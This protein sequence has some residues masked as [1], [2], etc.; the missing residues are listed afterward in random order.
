MDLFLLR[1]KNALKSV[2]L[3]T[4]F[5]LMA[6]LL[7]KA[8]VTI[9]SIA[10]GDLL[11]GTTGNYVLNGTVGNGPTYFR[12]NNLMQGVAIDGS[13]N[14]AFTQLGTSTISRI[15]G[16]HIINFP[17]A[18][19]IGA[20]AIDRDNEF[21]Y[22]A[23]PAL[24]E[25]TPGIINRYIWKNTGSTTSIGYYVGAAVSTSATIGSTT[26][27]IPFITT[28][29]LVFMNGAT[30]ATALTM[31]L[32]NLCLAFDPAGNLYYADYTNN[33]VR[34][35]SIEK[36]TPA[37]AASGTTTIT[38]SAAPS[39]AVQIGD[40]VS[41]LFIPASTYITA[42]SGSSITLSKATTGAID[43]TST[44]A[45]ITGVSDI[46]NTAGTAGGV[47]AANFPAGAIAG[48]TLIQL[49]YGLTFDPSGNM[50]LAD[51]YGLNPR[52][53]KI[54]APVSSTSAIAIFG[55]GYGNKIQGLATDVNGNLY[56]ADKTNG[57][58]S[59]I[60]ANGGPVS[61][62][63]G[64][65]GSL[66]LSAYTT[67]AGSP[68]ISTTDITNL[69]KLS[70]G[71]KIRGT[72][73]PNAS[74]VVAINNTIA[75]YTVTI[76]NPAG[77]TAAT[78][79]G[80]AATGSTSLTVTSGGSGGIAAGQ[81]VIGAGIAPNTTVVSVSGTTVTLSA[82]TSAPLAITQLFFYA[83]TVF[84][85]QV[86]STTTNSSS[87]DGFTTSPG[88]NGYVE[89]PFGIAVS[90][91]ANNPFIV[92]PEQFEKYVRKISGSTINTSTAAL[93][94]ITSFT[95]SASALAGATI[96]ITG[97]NFTGATAVSFG[98][99][100]AASF[101]VV[102]ATSITAVI[103][104]GTTG[105]IYVT[106]PGGTAVSS[107][108][109]KV[110]PVISSFTPTSGPAGGTI[111]IT[112]NNFLGATAVT[113]GG[114]TAASFT[115]NGNTTITAVTGASATGPIAVTTAAGTGTS[116]GTFT[117][118]TAPSAL[119]YSTNTAAVN[120]GT[121]GT[122][123]TP[124][125]NG[126]APTYNLS[127]T[128]PA[129]ISI[130]AT[131]GVISYAAT[132]SAGTYALSVVATNNFPGST[133]A[134]YTITVSAVAPSAL[135]Y[136]QAT[137]TA[138]Y[139]IAGVSVAP[140]INNGGATITY[141]LG[142]TVPTGVSID[143]ST[144]IIS[145][146][147]TLLAGNYPLTIISTNSAG[148]TTASYTI[149]ISAI[150]PSALVY[151]SSTTTANYGTAGTSVTPTINNGGAAITYSLDGTVPIGISIDATTGVISYAA[152]LNAGTYALSVLATNS[153]SSTGVTYTI[154]VSA[155]AP[156]ALAYSPA[157][158]SANYSTS[159]VS[160]APT[161]N[162]GGATI[163]YSLSGTVPVGISIDATTGIISY[164]ATLNVGTYTLS[165]IATNSAGN[166][167]AAYTLTVNAIAPSLLVYNPVSSTTLRGT[168][169]V[170]ASPS[171][172]N[173][174]AAI[175]YSLSGTV[176]IGISINATTGV[177]SYAAT[178]AAGTYTLSVVAT[179]SAGNTTASYSITVSPSS[180]A[181]LTS[182][183]VSSGAL[184]PIFDA[185]TTSYVVGV[186]TGTSSITFTPT[187]SDNG[188][189]SVKVNGITVT[190]GNAS[191]PITLAIGSNPINIIVTAQNASTKTYAVNVIKSAFSNNAKLSSLALSSGALS[192][193]FASGTNTYT[194]NVSNVTTSITLTPVL[195]D[196]TATV[197]VNGTTVVSGN[198]SSPVT[199]NVG[200]NEVTTTV[201]AQD[202]VTI[203]T[204]TVTVTRAASSNANL[205]TL[206]LSNGT[207]SP[208]FVSTTGTYAASVANSITSITLTPGVADANA[209]VK[210][211]GTTVTSGTASA[212][213]ALTVGANTITAS[214]TA[215]DGTLNTY[216]VVVTR[217]ASSNANLSNL[218][219]SNGTLSP[220]FLS[221]TAAYAVT[222][223]G[224]VTSITITPTVADAT[225]TVKVNGTTVNSGSA[226]ASQ[227]LI[228]GS[229]VINTIVTA[230]DGTIK[231]YT[232]T[233][234]RSALPQTIT[235]APLSAVNYGSADKAPGA[236]SSNT[237]IPVTYTSSNTAVATITSAGS[238]HVV[239][240]GSTTIT[241]SQAADATY[242]AATPVGQTLTVNPV[243]LTITASNQS[244]VYGIANPTFGL[245]YAGFVNG[246]NAASLTTAPITSTTATTT[247]A[248]GIYPI[249]VSGAVSPNYVISYVSGNLTI[250]VGT[251]T[252][253]FAA[254]SAK[255]YGNPDF[256]LGATITSGETIIYTS[257][258]PTIATVVNGVV[259]IILP[260]T[261][262]IT[263]AAPV[264]SNYNP[265]TL[266][267]ITQQLVINR[268]GQTID[269]S[270]IP[271]QFKGG[272]LV[273]N[274]TASSGLPVTF[275]SYD[276]KVAAV[277]GQNIDLLTAG[278]TA[279]TAVQA[280][281]TYYLPA[282]ANQ[283]LVVQ[284]N[285]VVVHTGVSPNA[286]GI[287]DYLTIDGIN[288]YPDN[289]LT[290]VNKSGAQIFQTS[291]YNNNTNNF[292]GH[293][294]NGSVMLAGTYF[295]E[296]VIKVNG[297]TKKM[298]GYIILKYN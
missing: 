107:S 3:M 80:T 282:T 45:I 169:G 163:T 241:A 10:A 76:S 26:A 108:T 135:A 185:N 44:L 242:N 141:S 114:T 20:L 6:P 69:N 229:N 279:I 35:I 257:S 293:A 280:G 198:A 137:T 178:L 39:A 237:T 212:G 18:T 19:N 21:I 158:K 221:T 48:T 291:G 131:T 25:S 284:D 292:D 27:T 268:M 117:F 235:F 43:G 223:P 283:F 173:G 156:S 81:Y 144:G 170:S 207:L 230:A 138:N 127:G 271:A 181:D 143:A 33:I 245:T 41:G 199:L 179:N 106:T 275:T 247:S 182:L 92:Y 203:S 55:S 110:L 56:V 288:D 74:T 191:T 1:L 250:T 128:V 249:T 122:S 13:N 88:S 115:V 116:S 148:N 264:N 184:T 253:V 228:V 84:G 180:N 145:Y 31:G 190:S 22:A 201:T 200:A 165:V 125:V 9:S 259:H 214:V 270:R 186:S 161:I 236:S 296:L 295:Y 195:A 82:P 130:D 209:T 154:T 42:K 266:P 206:V 254:L 29:D 290:I 93:P 136:S 164:A 12:A 118:V 61:V 231:T 140:T 147:N 101:T 155:I 215:Q 123:V 278:T 73:I 100:N 2:I 91:D 16:N 23:S 298:A 243:N 217:A 139:G 276:P 66:N 67:T 219:L 8:Q 248:T 64:T 57:K 269:F 256:T 129:G 97:T 286:D 58:I 119:V 50:F 11:N 192:P 124:T 225:A 71:M 240:A 294:S 150:A 263:A 34:K 96:T 197:T 202:G 224:T 159:G 46:V 85:T 5:T 213:Q 59:K 222:V 281:D 146:A 24:S 98:G 70:P 176:P 238:I 160:V 133:T 104:T 258:D 51:Q 289:K 86:A 193:V 32:N 175:T 233:V 132:L 87:E 4:I 68:V 260:G 103:G 149:T 17:A 112:G 30:T 277:N 187:V 234:T 15:D 210:V 83:P 52:I 183:A 63:V 255:T 153:A 232:V 208:A 157:T 226:S 204:Y 14:I 37:A 53:L 267:V 151:S 111:T 205:S 273:L 168:A 94:T 121:A 262:T 40:E 60:S 47:L 79:D 167:S 113:I 261:V 162:S 72:G 89:N 95:P 105:N 75:P 109:L 211:N 274:A 49:P 272:T 196:A 142:G 7:L 220:A 188:Y 90:N 36:A 99:N 174:G 177:I 246:D 252:L 244:R 239:G 216:T 287:N 54:S 297:E 227:A 28:G 102:S 166:T 189:A 285:P 194:A 126:G 251:R 65:A 172:S 38:L 265:A 171:V 78:P 62:L 218:V 77:V 120:Y 134:T 152:S